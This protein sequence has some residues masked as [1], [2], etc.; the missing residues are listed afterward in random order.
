[1]RTARVDPLPTIAPASDAARALRD[2]ARSLALA[3]QRC[4][5]AADLSARG[6]P[7][8]CILRDV[9]EQI[10]V[11]TV[12]VEGVIHGGGPVLGEH[13]GLFSAELREAAADEEARRALEAR[14]V[15]SF[16]MNAEDGPTAVENLRRLADEADGR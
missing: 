1:M 3:A 7:I 15:R 14:L 10:A 4:V 8:A 12:K 9:E 6:A 5:D 13:V 11:A 2:A 16:S